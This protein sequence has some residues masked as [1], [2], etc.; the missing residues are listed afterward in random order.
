[1]NSSG[2]IRLFFCACTLAGALAVSPSK[3]DVVISTAAS[4]NMTCSGG[5]CAPTNNSAVLNAGDLET[6]LAAGGVTIVTINGSVQANNIDIVTKVGW[7]NSNSLKL[8][9]YQSITITGAVKDEGAGGVSLITNDGGSG[10]ALSF[11]AKGNL[12]FKNLKDALSING[13]SYKLG[14]SIKSLARAIVANP[15]GAFALAD[16]YNAKKDGVYR[17]IPIPVLFGGQFNG[18]GHAISS[19]EIGDTADY[20]VGFFWILNGPGTI[21]S[22]GLKDIIVQSGSSYYTVGVV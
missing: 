2:R 6:M 11:L 4:Q 21:S 20:Y 16:N 14:N 5:V 12:S 8:D 1:M 18:L 13:T 17:S 10:G 7:K 22:F 15:N 9:A 19:V 3:A